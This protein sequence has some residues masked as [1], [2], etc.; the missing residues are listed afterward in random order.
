M[1]RNPVFRNPITGSVVRVY[2]VSLI[3]ATRPYGEG[4]R[5]GPDQKLVYVLLCVVR[6]VLLHRLY[7]LIWSILE[8]KQMFGNNS[9]IQCMQSIT[10][11]TKNRTKFS[12][13]CWTSSLYLWNKIYSCLLHILLHKAFTQLNSEQTKLPKNFSVGRY[14]FKNVR[15]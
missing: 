7:R 15:A 9:L 5:Y 13:Q 14:N 12:E 3:Q 11:T 4:S 8:K 10:W 2:R 1:K 6:I